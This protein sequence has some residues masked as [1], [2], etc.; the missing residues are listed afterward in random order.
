MATVGVGPV[1][2]TGSLRRPWGRRMGPPHGLWRVEGVNQRRISFS[3]RGSEAE[4]VR[5]EGCADTDI[6]VA[7][8]HGG[9]ANE[10]DAR[11]RVDPYVCGAAGTAKQAEGPAASYALLAGRAGPE[12]FGGRRGGGS[13]QREM[14]RELSLAPPR[15]Q[16]ERALG[17]ASVSIMSC[18]QQHCLALTGEKEQ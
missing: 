8:L 6:V 9:A 17:P 4:L 13:A 3:W 16:R 15:M 11:E 18:V 10:R 14:R 7:L 12:V 1:H 5:S 2:A